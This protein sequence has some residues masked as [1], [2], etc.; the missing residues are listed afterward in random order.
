MDV[1]HRRGLHAET[2]IGTFGHDRLIGAV[3]HTLHALGLV[4]KIGELRTRALVAGG[5]DV[6]DV[7]GNDFQIGLLGVHTGG[8]DGKSSHVNIPA[9]LDLHLGNVEIGRHDLVSERDGGLQ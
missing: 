9:G 8:S 6:G 3:R 4:E 5:V 2:D 1:T 7:V